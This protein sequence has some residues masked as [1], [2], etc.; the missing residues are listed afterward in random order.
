MCMCKFICW[1]AVDVREKWESFAAENVRIHVDSVGNIDLE[2]EIESSGNVLF[3]PCY[4]FTVI[5]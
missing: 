1:R 4:I 5:K 2:I 3:W